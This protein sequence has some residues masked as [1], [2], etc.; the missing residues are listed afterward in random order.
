MLIGPAFIAVL[1]IGTSCLKGCVNPPK[2]LTTPNVAP[3]FKIFKSFLSSSF[4]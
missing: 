3:L 4:I 2:A 1:N